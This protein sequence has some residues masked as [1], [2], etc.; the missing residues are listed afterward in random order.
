[1]D[2]PP[3]TLTAE[4]F[5]R[6]VPVAAIQRAITPQWWTAD[7]KIGCSAANVFAPAPRLVRPLSKAITEKLAEREAIKLDGLSIALA[8]YFAAYFRLSH[9]KDHS[10][11]IRL[12]SNV[13]QGFERS[14]HAPHSGPSGS[15]SKSSASCPLSSDDWAAGRAKGRVGEPPPDR[16][17]I[18]AVTAPDC[19]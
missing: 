10:F 12:C 7:G 5:F 18:T 13:G 17:L 19:W 16:T 1:M 8:R 4:R 6:S 9:G 2:N 11:E 15:A 3:R 14:D